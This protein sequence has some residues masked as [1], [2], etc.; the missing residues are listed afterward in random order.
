MTIAAGAI[1]EKKTAEGPKVALVYRD[2]Y[3]PEWS[4]P[5]GKVEPGESYEEAAL[6][7]VKEETFCV[8]KI[9]GYAGATDYIVQRVPKVVLFW[10]MTLESEHPFEPTDET[11]ELE[12][13]SPQAAFQKL[14]HQNQREILARAYALGKTMEKGGSAEQGG[15]SKFFRRQF[16]RWQRLESSIIS[17]QGE[18]TG[19]RQLVPKGCPDCFDTIQALLGDARQQLEKG[20]LDTGWKLFHAARR[21]EL[22]SFCEKDQ[23]KTM[24]REMGQEAAK[25][26]GWRGEA[27]KRLVK[28]EGEPPTV[29][30]L[31]QAALVRDEYFANNAYKGDIHRTHAIALAGI[32]AVTLFMLFFW[33]YTHPGL[34]PPLFGLGEK[35][36]VGVESWSIFIVVGL[37]G[38]L[39]GTISAITAVSKTLEAARI[40]EMTT[41]FQVT[42]L[43][44]FMGFASAIVIVIVLNSG[45][46]KEVLTSIISENLA[47]AF[48]KGDPYTSYFVAFCAGFSERLVKRAAEYVAGR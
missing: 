29:E 38:I 4:L 2:R 13:L 27:I 8:G 12:W 25:I 7:E 16:K 15:F 9:K 47:E 5:K 21:M 31:Y 11:K 35:N 42:F 46:G 30:A 48:K 34:L 14:T 19:L 39:G 45:L 3:G 37:F 36:I 32:L 1:L 44:L 28:F 43:R 6:R 41:S 18:L 33:S 20:D 22:I 24:A 17:Y 40:P 26:K 10:H 23:R